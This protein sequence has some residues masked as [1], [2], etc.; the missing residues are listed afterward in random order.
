MKILHFI[1]VASFASNSEAPETVFGKGLWDAEMVEVKT[2][3]V[4]KIV[5]AEGME[6]ELPRPIEEMG[7][8]MIGKVPNPPVEGIN[9]MEGWLIDE[10]DQEEKMR[11]VLEHYEKNFGKIHNKPKEDP[12]LAFLRMMSEALGGLQEEINRDFSD[13][14]VDKPE[15]MEQG[16]ETEG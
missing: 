12:F 13:E 15:E 14:H 6:I 8:N 2:E 9:E 16:H 1:G 5:T 4:D 3:F 11:E 7:K 10:D